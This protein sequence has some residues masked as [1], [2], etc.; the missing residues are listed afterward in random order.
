MCFALAMGGCVFGFLTRLAENIFQVL[1][2]EG[3]RIDGELSKPA[4]MASSLSIQTCARY[5]ALIATNHDRIE[6]EQV[7][8]VL[9]RRFGAI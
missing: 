9:Q 8:P 1:L 7:D 6:L 3:E 5:P 2:A 4:R